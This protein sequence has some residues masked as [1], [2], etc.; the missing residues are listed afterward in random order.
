MALTS[1]LFPPIWQCIRRAA[2]RSTA[3]M[4]EV[5][6]Q[7]LTTAPPAVELHTR[8]IQQKAPPGLAGLCGS[9]WSGNYFSSAA[10]HGV[11]R[12]A[13][14]ARVCLTVSAVMDGASLDQ[15]WRT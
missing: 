8:S 1:C 9:G 7:G 11:V 5:A 13:N 12:E 6:T 2:N 15:D 14:L 3:S 10:V 4:A